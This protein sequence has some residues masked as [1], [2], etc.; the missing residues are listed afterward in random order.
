MAKG[1][2]LQELQAKGAK[3][4]GGLTLQQ[5][6]QRQTVTPSSFVEPEQSLSEKLWS[7]LAGFGKA[8]AA[9]PIGFGKEIAAGIGAGQATRNNQAQVAQESQNLDIAIKKRAELK[10]RGVDTSKVDA[11]I[12][13]L[14]T[15]LGKGSDVA[16]VL[17]AVNDTTSQVLGNAGGIVVDIA[18][19]GGLAN[20]GKAVIA[21]K[22]IGQGILQGAKT[23]ATTG[24]IVGG[25]Q[26]FTKGLGAGQSVTDAAFT[27][28]SSATLGGVGGG[29]IG[30]AVGG[31]SGAINSRA[32]N[33]QQLVDDLT[34]N[35]ELVAKYS[36]NDTGAIVKDPKASEL[37]RQGL[38]EKQVAVIKNAAPA[39]K[40]KFQQMVT[41]AEKATKDARAV[42]RPSDV[43]G[44]TIV[45]RTKHLM[46]Q[47]KIAGKEVD[48][49][50]QTLKGQTV[51]STPVTLQFINDLEDI[52]VSFKNGQ[53]VFDGSDI[54]GIAPAENLI[55]KVFA[56]ADDASSDAVKIHQLKKFI[57]EQVTF[58]KMGEGLSGKTEF[59]L[60]SFR[61]NLD[62]LLDSNFEN[63]NAAN[64]G[65]KKAIDLLDDTKTVLGKNFDPSNG[66]VRAGA[67]AR[68]VLGNSASR[69]DILEYLKSVD[70]FYKS[71]GGTAQDDIIG[72]T[73]FADILEEL[74]GTQAT[75]GL[76]G[77]VQRGVEA[78][79]GAG[80]DLLQGKF[81]QSATK[82][83]AHV[84][85][86]SRGLSQEAK[87]AALKALIQ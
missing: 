65:F 52:G 17:P 64:V 9:S 30:G 81:L 7:G 11:M 36:L 58:G 87:I 3:P 39:D 63:Y 14:R 29:I 76:Q 85:E 73:V 20:A 33:R 57:D 31:V 5:L 54:E 38:P 62:G 49:A 37:I 72:Q 12:E 80:K 48:A 28:A 60:K 6:Q 22:T 84:A 66:S 74:Y 45:E 43:V 24:V 56:R 23:G 55:K 59:I 83:V 19:A 78:A 34:N 1:L 4:S 25:A 86:A 8:V 35:P 44:Q 46:G 69:G 16:S 32:A 51:D 50:A 41:L 71:T 82:A 70:D 27:A 77:Q 68:R 15:N 53:P 10:A 40:V 67:V 26:G 79:A 2:T 61:R 18:S 21:P 75:T 42:E 47:L 13:D